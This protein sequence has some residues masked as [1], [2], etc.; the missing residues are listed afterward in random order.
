[1]EYGQERSCP[2]RHGC[3][4]TLAL[5]RFDTGPRAKPKGLIEYAEVVKPEPTQEQAEK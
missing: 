2:T 4:A 3:T 1:M 5:D